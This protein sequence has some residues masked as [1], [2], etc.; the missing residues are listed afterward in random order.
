MA[1]IIA[2]D[3]LVKSHVDRYLDKSTS[4]YTR[5]LE[6]PP[7][8][9]IYYSRDNVSSTYDKGL[10]NTEQFLGRASSNRFNKIEKFP[11]Y[12]IS[13]WQIALNR[14]DTGLA[15]DINSEAVILPNTIKPAP[16]DFFVIDYLGEIYIMKV[17]SVVNDAIKNSPFYRI[18]F[19]LDQKIEDPRYLDDFVDREYISMFD[20]IGTNKDNVIEKNDFLIIDQI[21]KMVAEYIR[22]YTIFFFNKKMNVME[23]GYREEDT[24][25]RIMLFNRYLN[26]FIMD[27]K[28]FDVPKGNEQ[29]DFY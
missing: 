9:V 2:T 28:L 18:N 17:I 6:T 7:T 20:N 23:F 24:Q 12:D 11:L 16:N 25:K 19:E 15:T 14:D 29:L 27:N 26:R 10:E 3:E 21:D 8:F 1:K 22:Q 4:Q 5:F 13:Q